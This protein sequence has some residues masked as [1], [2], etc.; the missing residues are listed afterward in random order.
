M[1]RGKAVFLHDYPIYK[2]YHVCSQWHWKVKGKLF[3]VELM[4]KYRAQASL[5]LKIIFFF[6]SESFSPL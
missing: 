3:L 2:G 1:G 4:M 5:I 6:I